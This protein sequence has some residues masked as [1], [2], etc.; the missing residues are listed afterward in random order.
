[1]KVAK[2]TKRTQV[3]ELSVPLS[4]PEPWYFCRI[5]GY[6]S[7]GTPVCGIP[8]RIL[9]RFWYSAAISAAIFLECAVSDVLCVDSPFIENK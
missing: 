7:D 8:V 9:D 6:I 1:M 2:V 5:K 4:S 3:R